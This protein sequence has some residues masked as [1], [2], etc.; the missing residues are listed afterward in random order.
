MNSK[1]IE[2]ELEMKLLMESEMKRLE[3][4]FKNLLSIMSYYNAAEAPTWVKETYSR[5]ECKEKLLEASSLLLESG[6][7]LDDLRNLATGYLC[8][9]SDYIPLWFNA[10]ERSKR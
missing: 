6:R 8:S 2:F 1:Q 9:E 4:N 3:N 5:R 10:K 7:N